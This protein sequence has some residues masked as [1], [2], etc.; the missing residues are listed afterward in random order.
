[1]TPHEQ[2]LAFMRE[3]REVREATDDELATLLRWQCQEAWRRVAVLR[4]MDRRGPR[5]GETWA[6]G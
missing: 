5:R 4:E 6:I 3:V 2:D 1:M